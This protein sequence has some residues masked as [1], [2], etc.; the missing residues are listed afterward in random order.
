MSYIGN[1]KLSMS[2]KR[3]WEALGYLKPKLQFS[4]T[5]EFYDAFCYNRRSLPF[6]FAIKKR[7]KLYLVE[8]SDGKLPHPNASAKE[9]FCGANNIP[10]L[11][12]GEPEVW[13]GE[14]EDILRGFLNTKV[15]GKQNVRPSRS[16][17]YFWFYE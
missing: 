7:G 6:D 8:F 14:L 11:V 16:S 12:L 17:W 15:T 4:Y 3:V 1:V 2:A 5:R 9:Q 10:L 13:N